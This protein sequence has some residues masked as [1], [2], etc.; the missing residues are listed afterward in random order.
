MSY[1]EDMAR[2]QGLFL[3]NKDNPPIPHNTPPCA[4]AVLWCRG[5]LSR[6]QQP[7]DK[8]RQLNRSI[9][10]RE[11]A[12]SLVKVCARGCCAC[13]CMAIRRQPMPDG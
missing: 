3:E 5:L 12:R 13:V 6:L 4:G 9:L 8:L 10:D 7:M 1:S 11:E 2:I